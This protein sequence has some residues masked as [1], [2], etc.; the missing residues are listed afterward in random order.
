MNKTTRP[1]EDDEYLEIIKTIR[2]GFS[3]NGIMYKP[4]ERIAMVLQLERN[5]GI[6][7]SDVL[8][9]TPKSFVKV[10]EGYHINI[11]EKKT[12]KMR[13]FIVPNEVYIVIAE[14][15]M[16]KQIKPE[17]RLFPISERMVS[18][19][20]QLVCLYLGYRGIGT[21]SFRKAFA[22]QAY[23]NSNYNIEIVRLLL[24]HNNLSTTQRYVGVN[25][26]EVKDTLLRTVMLC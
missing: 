17:A 23:V 1:V 20:L 25:A 24:Q 8:R 21:H 9:L 18:R 5:L 2:A 11:C 13:N 3:Y 12:K 6:R 15:A 14:Y 16:K 22:T 4:N 26:K 7:V 10:S 19:H